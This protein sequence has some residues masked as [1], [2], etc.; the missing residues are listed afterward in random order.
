MAYQG[1]TQDKPC[2]PSHMIKWVYLVDC[3]A[4]LSIYKYELN[5]KFYVRSPAGFNTIEF[6]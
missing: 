5:R 3:F 1:L 6:W 2:V 4:V